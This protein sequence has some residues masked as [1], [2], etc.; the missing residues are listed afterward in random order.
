MGN[1]RASKG[2]L[3]PPV[4]TENPDAKTRQQWLAQ[5]KNNFV[6]SPA[7]KSIYG[8]LLEMLWPPGHGIPGP[9]VS[10]KA[11]RQLLDQTRLDSGKSPYV[12]PFR[13]MRELQGEEGF[14]CI[15]KEGSHYQLQHLDVGPKREPRQK[16]LTTEWK[17]IKAKA[18]N[19]C[20]HCGKQEPDIKLSPDHR[21]PRSR[22]G[23]NSLTNWQPL[24]EQ[25]NNLKSS[26]CS[27]CNLNCR[28]CS[29]AFPET[30][31]PIVISDDNKELIRR[32][33]ERSKISQS[34]FTNKI[35]RGFFNR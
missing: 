19:R 30:Y 4:V 16:P 20:S 14:T 7:N 33:A 15:V 25:C 23:D 17:E 21:V 6:C 31:K 35:L 22:G 29:W 2:L 13:R 9:H 12:D 24:C 18:A 32:E 26:A 34:D 1:A 27:G 28:V 5:A 8:M 10:E 3:Y 11:I